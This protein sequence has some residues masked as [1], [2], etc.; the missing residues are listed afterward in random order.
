MREDR[1]TTTVYVVY[2]A[3]A[4]KNGSSLNEMFK[5]G[6]CPLLKIFETLLRPRCH[7]F[8]LVADI[9]PAFLNIR[10]KISKILRFL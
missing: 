4:N 9:Q 8:L 3:S 1:A 2:N 5:T 10:V 7:K 6:P